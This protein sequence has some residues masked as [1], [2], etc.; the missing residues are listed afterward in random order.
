MHHWKKLA[1]VAL[2]TLAACDDTGDSDTDV[3]NVTPIC[4]GRQQL[5]EED[6]D[7]PFDQDGDGFFDAS[8]P[9]CAA[10]WSVNQLD[11]DD[12]N[13]DVN[14]SQLEIPCNGVDDDCNENS[15]E[16]RD[17]DNDGVG[18]CE[19]CDDQNPEKFPGNTEECFDDIDND[20]DGITDNDCGL[21]YNGTWQMDT[22]AHFEC[23]I[24]FPISQTLV[25]FEMDQFFVVWTPPALLVG[26]PTS[27]TPPPM[28]GGVHPDG[29][30]AVTIR[31]GAAPDCVKNWGFQGTFLDAETFEGAITLDINAP[32]PGICG[33]C[34]L[35]PQSW[36]FSAYKL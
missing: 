12:T 25:Q 10:I 13:P 31:E 6:V 19:D 14:P 7:A 22:P 21:D 35:M 24:P 36:E 1:L 16:S 20:C 4:D 3:D 23:G 34:P 27:A 2:T 33:T 18:T 17:G 32:F 28:E 30:V 5:D 26:Q 8:N 9:D 29:T 15:P 11:C